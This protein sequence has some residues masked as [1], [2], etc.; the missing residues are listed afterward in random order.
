MSRAPELEAVLLAW[1]EL[2]TCAPAEQAVHKRRLDELLD[3]AVAKA[4]MK[5]VS[6]RD[7]MMALREQYGEF[8][9]AR[10]IEQRQRLSRLR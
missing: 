3:A 10:H 7:L 8:A 2:E 1:F 6:R 9:K 5:G 4:G